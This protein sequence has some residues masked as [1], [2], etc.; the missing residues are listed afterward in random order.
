MII[1]REKV[2]YENLNTSFT[3]FEE[4]IIN[5]KT[6]HFTGIIQI[7]FWEYEGILFLDSGRVINAIEENA[8]KR[9]YGQGAIDNLFAKVTEKDGTIS[10]F[11]L[12]SE[13]VT[14]LA[15]A[16][17]NEIVYK[18]LSSDFT[19]LEK[20][21]EKLKIEQH[22]GYIEILSNNEK[23]VAT[24]FLQ[25]GEP[26]ESIMTAD[27][28]AIANSGVHNE[29]FNLIESQGAIFNVYKTMMGH[30][31]E[32]MIT[33]EEISL[34]M[35]IWSQIIVTIERKLPSG[36]FIR[37]FKDI[38]IE[39]ADEYP[40]LDPFSAE[41]DYRDQKATFEGTLPPDFNKGLNEVLHEVIQR[42]QITGITHEIEIIQKKF[43]DLIL[44][45]SLGDIVEKLKK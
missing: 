15:G 38:L 43:S 30:R 41:F 26:L 39:K 40:F 16:I 14:L 45:F 23:H 33:R 1:P 2:I 44:K 8:G 25:G 9:S 35:D 36:I 11:G 27:G 3:S 24:I 12:S 13:L 18:D 29:I 37:I 19:N 31:N 32:R 5:L 34:L 7:Q 21:L 10:V 6:N 20:L 22:T 17:K 4:L 28:K 42:C